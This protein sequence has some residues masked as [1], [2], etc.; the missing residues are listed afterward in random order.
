MNITIDKLSKDIVNHILADIGSLEGAGHVTF[1]LNKREKWAVAKNW[2]DIITNILNSALSKDQ[3]YTA[4]FDGGATPNP[5]DM[6]IGG[7]I[8]DTNGTRIYAYTEEI[9]HGTNNEAEY[10]SLIKLLEELKKRGI[11]KVNI[12][13]DSALVV[14]QV[15][16][17]WKAKDPKMKEL[18]NK[19]LAITGVDYNLEHVLRAFNSEADS[20]T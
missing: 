7:W 20:L 5:G 19:V 17:K 1:H 10:R 3:I 9:G 6:K 16:G 4:A 14:N 8:R 12:Q 18:K 13:G 11:K 15:N 2:K